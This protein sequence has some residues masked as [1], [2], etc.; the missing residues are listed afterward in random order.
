MNEQLIRSI[1][2][3]QDAINRRTFLTRAAAGIGMAALGSLLATVCRR[4]RRICSR[5]RRY[6]RRCP[7]WLLFPAGP[8]A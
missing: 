7:A 2:Q 4:W 8:S 3:Q 5:E 1:L 6:P